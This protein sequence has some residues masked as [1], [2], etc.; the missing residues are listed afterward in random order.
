MSMPKVSRSKSK[1]GST[2]SSVKRFQIPALS[3]PIKQPPLD[4]ALERLK[5][6]TVRRNAPAGEDI[7][8]IREIIKG[9]NREVVTVQ[10]FVALVSPHTGDNGNV[11]R[12]VMV[13]D[14]ATF[15]KLAKQ[16][17]DTMT[18]DVSDV[19][20]N[21]QITVADYFN[22]RY[23]LNMDKMMRTI[24]EIFRYVPNFDFE[25]YYTDPDYLK[26]LFPLPKEALDEVD[27]EEQ[28]MQKRQEVYHRLQW[29]RSEGMRLNEE[30][31]H[32]QARLRQ[33]KNQQKQ[34]LMKSYK[35][36]EESEQRRSELEATEANLQ[37]RLED[38]NESMEKD[39]IQEEEEI[40]LAQDTKLAIPPKPKPKYGNVP[41][42]KSREPWNVRT[43]KSIEDQAM[44][45]AAQSAAS[46]VSVTS[47]L[48]K[49]GTVKKV[50]RP[51]IKKKVVKTKGKRDVSPFHYSPPRTPPGTARQTSPFHYSP[52]KTPT[53][54]R[55]Q[56]PPPEDTIP[57]R[58]VR[59]ETTTTV[60]EEL[61][62]DQAPGRIYGRRGLA[63][64]D[65]WRGFQ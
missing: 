13:E 51:K 40:R 31:A 64:K 23:T 53:E 5:R 42:R 45:S 49:T 20:A 61:P 1:P 63:P 41:K 10:E 9:L 16:V 57:S 27:P 28:A 14:L 6:K 46:T 2:R 52:P 30:N 37:N 26:R 12:S 43:A 21:E 33:L 36:E 59:Y 19:L 17:Y 38:L 54:E 29:M 50:S 56:P 25:I 18:Q 62:P 22:E 55:A 48:S 15:R 58:T 7:K 65:T 47:V 24:D 34:E 8:K 4:P 44:Q 3:V 39:I 32:L 35:L 11:L 60:V